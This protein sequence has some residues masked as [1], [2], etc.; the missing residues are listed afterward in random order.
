M[1]MPGLRARSSGWGEGPGRFAIAGA[2]AKLPERVWR[3]DGVEG[4][5]ARQEAA[6][7]WL[8]A[9]YRFTRYRDRPAMQ[10][11]L[12]APEGVDLTRDLINTPARTWARGSWNMP[13]ARLRPISAP[14]V[15]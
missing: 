9:G 10:A 2:A 5:V 12:I 4:V 1:P 13:C 6:L 14:T 8:L 7:A 11:R 15:K 3:L